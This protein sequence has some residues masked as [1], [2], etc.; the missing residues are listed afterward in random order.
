MASSKKEQIEAYFEQGQFLGVSV[1]RC[2]KYLAESHGDP[3]LALTTL[4][5]KESAKTIY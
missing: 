1:E 5:M 2:K 3:A 4:L